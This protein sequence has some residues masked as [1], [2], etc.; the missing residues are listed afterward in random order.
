MSVVS[1]VWLLFVGEW[2]L[3]VLGIIAGIVFPYV[4]T[5]VTL[6]SLGLVFIGMVLRKKI[7]ILAFLFNF[8]RDY[9]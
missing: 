7:F 5:I 4:E 1:T 8:A 9:I 2:R 6:P 3:V